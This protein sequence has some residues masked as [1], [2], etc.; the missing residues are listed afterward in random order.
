MSGG[1]ERY[2]RWRGRPWGRRLLLA[3]VALVALWFVV[4][5]VVSD[6]PLVARPLERYLSRVLNADVTVEHA[7]ISTWRGRPRLAVTAIDVYRSGTNVFLASAD[8]LRAEL[9]VLRL[10][11]GELQ[12]RNMTI[13]RISI[14]DPRQ[15]LHRQALQAGYLS[16]PLMDESEERA[17]ANVQFENIAVNARLCTG[18]WNVA[19]ESDCDLPL[20]RNASCSAVLERDVRAGRTVI[21]QCVLR[22]VRVVHQRGIRNGKIERAELETPVRVDVTG[23][24]VR[25]V[26]D[27]P[28]ITLAL[29]QCQV[30]WGVHVDHTCAVVRVDTQGQSLT[31]VGRLANMGIRGN[32]IEGLSAH[33]VFRADRQGGR[34]TTDGAIT[35]ER[36]TLRAVPFSD[37]ALS[38]QLENDRVT[39]LT[40][41]ANLWNGS[42]QLAVL[43]TP[44]LVTP[45]GPLGTNTILAGHMSARRIDLNACLSC[46]DE[47]PAKCGGELNL[48]LGCTLDDPEELN[49]FN[50]SADIFAH[51]RGR[52]EVTVSNAYL[53]FFG[54]DRWQYSPRVPAMVRKYLGLAATLAAAP[55]GMPLLSKM[56]G[57]ADAHLPRV[58]TTTVE[59]DNGTLNTPEVTAVTPFGTLHATGRC[60]ENDALDYRMRLRLSSAMMQQYGDH[61]VLALFRTGD[62]IELPARLKGTLSQ[63]RL[64]LDMTPEQRAQFEERLMET[65][66]MYVEKRLKKERGEQVSDE[67]M[68]QDIKRV[69]DTVR[70]L[71]QRLL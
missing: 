15:A 31:D 5:Q 66:T 55:N 63:P 67:E 10:L 21:R 33:V 20:L 41:S 43:E 9:L 42:A 30:V 1:S 39:A 7:A 12:P 13:G 62:V 64:E 47:V 44:G 3:P 68:K 65:I 53:Q 71:I 36:G 49:L 38:F 26:V 59:I 35:I 14:D 52:G 23:S 4:P 50:L 51:L 24:V 45:G 37:M 25:G 18:V 19:L 61:P 11:L 8:N 32:A 70:G 57:V 2:G 17:P 29:G 56:T 6:T 16:R 58:V 69:E 60:G 27:L 34:L 54:S 28:R 46:F 22:G 48:D 40:A